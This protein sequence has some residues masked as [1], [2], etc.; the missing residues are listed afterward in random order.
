MVEFNQTA[1]GDMRTYLQGFGGDTSN[2]LIAAVRQGARGSYFTKLGDDEFGRMCLQLWRDEGV[3]VREIP[4]DPTAVTGIYFV[5][6]GQEG[7]TFSYLRAGSAASRMQP[8][9]VPVRL[10]QRAWFL[11]VS[12]ISQAISASA[13]DTVFRAIRIAKA[14]GVKVTY[15]PNLRLKLW[16]LDRAHA[17]ILATIPQAD[18]FLPSLDDVRLVSGLDD[19]DAIVDWCHRQGAPNVVL[20]LGREGS[21]AADGAR[22][23]PIS[24][25]SVEAV[26]ATGARRLL[27]RLVSRTP[28]R[29]RRLSL[30]YAMGQCSC[31]AD[32]DGLWR[33]RTL[34]DCRTSGALHG[35][36]TEPRSQYFQVTRSPTPAA[37]C[38]VAPILPYSPPGPE[39]PTP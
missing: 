8:S 22:R 16:P 31:R 15:D 2:A 13:T 37:H 4:I 18:Y 3:D 1:N 32:D 33:R 21:L 39:N 19:P 7:H 26:D 12:G 6:H 25:F 35:Q 14:A 30:G 17:I 20:K 36:G 5:R 29:R 9:D 11:P 34:A 23:T 24:A 27:R 10:I 28:C 38:L